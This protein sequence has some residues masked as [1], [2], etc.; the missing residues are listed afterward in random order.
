M[1]IGYNFPMQ[2]KAVN[3]FRIY[4]AGQNLFVITEYTGV[5]PEVRYVDTNDVDPEMGSRLHRIRWHPVWR[6]V[7]HTLRHAHLHWSVNLGF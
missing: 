5:D 1:S 6:D 2:G 7:E 4:V 3:K